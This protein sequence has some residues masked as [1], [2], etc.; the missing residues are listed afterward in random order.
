MVDIKRE[1]IT[2]QDWTKGISADEF[3][4]GSYF[5]AEWIQT[6]YN[7][8]WFKL[9]HR[10]DS[11]VLNYREEWYPVA[12]SP[13]WDYGMTIFT[14]DRRLETSENYNGSLD[15]GGDQQ[16][17][18]ALYAQAPNLTSTWLNGVT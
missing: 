14:Y 9:W 5:Y 13:A 16:W 17:G 3:A 4:W 8:K 10:L 1:D 7:T 12:I 11:E 18:W 2:L 15:G 6:W